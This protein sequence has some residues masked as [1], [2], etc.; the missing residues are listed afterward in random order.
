MGNGAVFQLVPQRFPK[1][2]GVITGLVGAAGG[3]GG[4]LLPSLLGAI[5]DKTGEYGI[6]LLMFAMAFLVASALLLLRGTTWARSWDEAFANRAG[7]FCFRS[8]A[9][10]LVA[11]DEN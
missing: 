6:G 11:A 8:L 2:V 9:R 7:V 4:F 10:N 3:F 1:Q 5:K